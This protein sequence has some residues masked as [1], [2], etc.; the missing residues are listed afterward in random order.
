MDAAEHHLSN[1][2]RPPGASPITTLRTLESA[3]A[4]IHISDDDGTLVSVMDV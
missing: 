2:A 4:L 3:N 1:L